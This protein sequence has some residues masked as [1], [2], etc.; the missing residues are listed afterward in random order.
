MKE[1]T[2]FNN[3]RITNDLLLELT[4]HKKNSLSHNRTVNL[5]QLIKGFV[6]LTFNIL[7]FLF[8]VRDFTINAKSKNWSIKINE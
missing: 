1:E 6:L 4:L 2:L 8:S 7:S 3:S 5:I